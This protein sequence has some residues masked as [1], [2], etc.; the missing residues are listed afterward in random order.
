MD[1]LLD[2]FSFAITIRIKPVKIVIYTLLMILIFCLISL[3]EYLYLNSDTF[4][5]MYD[6]LMTKAELQGTN[7]AFYLLS[8]LIEV[9]TL[10]VYAIISVVISLLSHKYNTSTKS[11]K[12]TKSKKYIWLTLLVV[13]ILLL[14]E[15][16]QLFEFIVVKILR[17]QE[18]YIFRS[19]EK[20]TFI[21]FPFA[22]YYTIY[23]FLI[24]KTILNFNKST[25]AFK[26]CT[27]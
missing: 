12:S 2:R 11:T 9:P 15:I 16:I 23:C 8:L 25:T 27:L 24:V 5:Y 10:V 7:S 20:H 19:T 18:L 3:F 1:G 13:N 4:Y 6:R 14:P 17:L 22:L 26:E 21:V